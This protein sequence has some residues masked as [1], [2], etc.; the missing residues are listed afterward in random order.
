MLVLAQ[1]VLLMP[2][3]RAGKQFGLGNTFLLLDVLVYCCRLD[4][5]ATFSAAHHARLILKTR[6]AM[7]KGAVAIMAPEHISHSCSEACRAQHTA[8]ITRPIDLFHR[9][10]KAQVFPLMFF[11]ALF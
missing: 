11:E 2:A 9:I 3:Q 7:G 10:T 1:A 4:L 8:C 6:Q 5:D